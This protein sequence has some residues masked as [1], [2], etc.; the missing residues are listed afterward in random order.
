MTT[1]SNSSDMS[2]FFAITIGICLLV[3]P[4]F[5]SFSQDSADSEL[6]SPSDFVKEMEDDFA[7][8]LVDNARWMRRSFGPKFLDD[9]LIDKLK[10]YAVLMQYS[11]ICY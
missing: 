5:Y 4:C 6:L 1:L 10:K 7:K 11:I 8:G 3:F 9:K 2:N